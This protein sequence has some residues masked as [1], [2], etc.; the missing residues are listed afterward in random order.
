MILENIVD[1]P[2]SKQNPDNVERRF[3]SAVEN[4]KKSS[5]GRVPNLLCGGP[6][7]AG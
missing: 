2:C 6:I 1:N 5:G 3:L 4:Q 7:L